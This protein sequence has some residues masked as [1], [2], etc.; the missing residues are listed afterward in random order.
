MITTLQEDDLAAWYRIA[1]PVIN[2]SIRAFELED[3]NRSLKQDDLLAE[4][5]LIGRGNE[6]TVHA[7]LDPGYAET[8]TLCGI[9]V[10]A[11]WNDSSLDAE[12]IVYS[13]ADLVEVTCEFCRAYSKRR[14]RAA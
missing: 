4:A 9:P 8:T 3:H 7:L 2:I 1:E 10:P 6:P 14:A 13:S 12:E 11:L 5:A